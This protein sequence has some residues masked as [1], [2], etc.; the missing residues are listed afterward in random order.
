MEEQDAKEVGTWEQILNNLMEK[1][2]T[3]EESDS[4]MWLPPIN[5]KQLTRT[6]QNI[7]RIK[8]TKTYQDKY[9]PPEEISALFTTVEDN[10][11]QS[12]IQHYEKFLLYQH[13]HQTL[14]CVITQHKKLTKI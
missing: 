10:L 11:A 7:K 1:D 9:T 5:H 2:E 6:R 3:I 12:L 4:Y 14:P 13:L 8:T